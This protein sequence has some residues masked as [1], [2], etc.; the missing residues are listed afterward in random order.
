MAIWVSLFSGYASRMRSV[1][2]VKCWPFDDANEEVVRASLPP[3]TIK[4]FSWW[5]DKLQLVQDDEEESDLGSE[6]LQSM[7]MRRSGKGKS[8]PKSKARA[9]APKK[10]S[11]VELF[12]VAPQVERV[13]S[14]DDDENGEYSHDEEEDSNDCS[15]EEDTIPHP[16]L[17]SFGK[18]GLNCKSKRKVK[19]KGILSMSK[20]EKIVMIKDLKKDKVKKKQKVKKTAVDLRTKKK[21]SDFY[22]LSVVHFLN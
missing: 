6:S 13:N 10:R 19:K 4:K 21:A 14:D 2:V 7:R 20:K 3:I 22:I 1:D 17:S 16:K 9:K 8:L 11:I 5:F 12:A 18:V 15:D